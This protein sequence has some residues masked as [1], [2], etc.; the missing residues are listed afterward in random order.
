MIVRKPVRLM[1][2]LGLLPRDEHLRRQ[3]V[4]RSSSSLPKAELEQHLARF[5]RIR[6]YANYD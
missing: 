5:E 2:Q 6:K 4:I 1:K 3:K